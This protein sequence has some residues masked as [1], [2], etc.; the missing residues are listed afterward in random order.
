MVN[1]FKA[2]E[3]RDQKEKGG[4]MHIYKIT[5]GF[6]EVELGL[7][8]KGVQ[9]ESIE[10]MTVMKI[11]N[12]PMRNNF[13]LNRNATTWNMLPSEIAEA[14]TVNQFKSRIDRRMTSET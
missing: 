9:K 2:D 1:K 5:K 3:S 10:D 7:R 11:V 12:A 13:L 14:D 6:E 4:L 8:Y